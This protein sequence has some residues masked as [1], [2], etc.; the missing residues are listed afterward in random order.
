M[1]QEYLFFYFVV[2][3]RK[4]DGSFLEDERNRTT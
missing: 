1:I 2:N 4:K 3:L